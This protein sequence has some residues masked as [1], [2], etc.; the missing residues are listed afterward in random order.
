[1]E[2]IKRSKMVKLSL[3]IIFRQRSWTYMQMNMNNEQDKN[4][5]ETYGRNLNE[6]VKEGKMD[7]VIG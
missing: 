5:L 6:M 4:P 3:I 1:M 2:L 7:P